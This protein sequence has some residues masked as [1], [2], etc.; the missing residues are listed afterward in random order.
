MS[1]LFSQFIGNAFCLNFII[2]S[3]ASVIPC[4]VK[5]YTTI[6]VHFLFFKSLLGE[7]MYSSSI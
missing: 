1:A 7:W 5:H 3:L 4:Y 6:T 2:L